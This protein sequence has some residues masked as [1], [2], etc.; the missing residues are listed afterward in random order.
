[1][2]ATILGGRGFVG[3]HLAQALR[4]DGVSVWVPERE[5]PAVFS[6]PL[7]TVYYC[8]GL[9]ADFRS[10]PFDTVDA[11]VGVLRR[12]LA[13]ADFEQL[14]YLSSTR[15]YAGLEQAEEGAALRLSP[16]LPD[17]LYNLSKAMGESLALSCGR[18]CTVVRL[19]NVLGPDMGATNFVGSVTAEAKATGKVRFL[20][21]PASAKDY[22]WIDDV[23]AGLRAIARTGTAGIYNL[24]GGLNISNATLAEILN[25]LGIE[26]SVAEGVK[27]IDFPAIAIERLER[28]TGF[29]PASV[30]PRLEAWWRR[31]FEG[32]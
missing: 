14:I 8:I 18:P 28:D 17:H 29:R 1:M 10:R 12:I 4:A 32:E 7:G 11:H 15:V 25:R 26:T 30:V 5:D 6:Q 3:R 20:S 2:S 22:I 16:D 27:R 19:S 24:A 23:T 31:E 21:D 9:T 13:E